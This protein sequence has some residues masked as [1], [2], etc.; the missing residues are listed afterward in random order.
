MK[1]VL[2]LALALFLSFADARIHHGVG[3]SLGGGGGGPPVPT[4]IQGTGSDLNDNNGITGNAFVI[5]LPN[6]TGTGNPI[7][8]SIAYPYSASRTWA[9]SDSCGDTWPAATVTGGTASVGNMN[10]KIYVLPNATGSCLHTLTVTFDTFIKPF[11]YAIAE[12]NNIATASPADGSHSTAN[13]ACSSITAGAYTP[14][15]N[16]DANGGH[17]IWNYAISNDPVGTGISTQATAISKT[18][19]VSPAFMHANNI[20]TI[21][22]ASSFDVQTT[23]G[24]INPGFG[25][26][27]STGTNCVDTSVALKVASAGTA[28]PTGIRVKRL[29]HYSVVNPQNGANV[30]LF[31]SDGNL[32]VASMA[33]G[34]NINAVSSVVDSGSQ[35]YTNPGAAGT[36]QVFYHQNATSGNNLTLTVNLSGAGQPQ[37]SIHLWDVVGAQASSFLNAQSFNGAAPGSGTVISNFPTITPIAAPGLVIDQTG[38]GTASQG[39]MAAGAPAGAVFDCVSYA[40]TGGAT[41]DQDRMDNAD[42]F[43][44]ANFA[45]TVTQNWNFVM[46]A[47][48][49]GSTAFAT[50][51]AFQ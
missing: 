37:F 29:L 25:F 3:M 24:A 43:G 15:T 32:L 28:A 20:A 23:N 11:H 50:A 27:Q 2:A 12:F 33:A 18:G 41:F 14:T 30:L 13:A 21:P 42:Q 17:L 45:T 47:A 9:I 44:H 49:H 4:F 6:A 10:T 39:A 36:S 38:S 5:N 40:I 26:T 35:T 7:L 1:K 19:G 34:N 31:P 51:I 16:N 22:S 8:L 48:Q 46:G